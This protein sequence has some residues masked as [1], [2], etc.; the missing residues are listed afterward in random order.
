[1]SAEQQ[2]GYSI[3]AASRLSG[4]S[5]EKIRIWERRYG[6]VSP[7]RDAANHRLYSRED[8][9]RLRLIQHLADQGHAVSTVA[10]LELTALRARAADTSADAE[11][12]ARPGHA[13][14]VTGDSALVESLRALGVR[15]VSTCTT[16]AGA[17]DWLA[18]GEADLL[19]IDQPT[20]LGQ[21]VAGI[22]RLHRL[23]PRTPML[24]TYRFAARTVL[25]QLER[26][27][28]RVSKAPLEVQ[29]LLNPTA[30]RL[31]PGAAEAPA[32]EAA[33]ARRYAPDALHRLASLA[34]TVQCECP[35]H[36]ADLV[37]DLQAFEDYSLGCES[38]SPDDAALHREI[39][40]VI[41]HARALVEDALGIVAA[42]EGI[43]L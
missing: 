27:G 3:S 35:R 14:A 2:G 6:A 20:L 26:L 24:V 28:I 19:L 17:G 32:P 11:Q 40:R 31:T 38:A 30:P 16:L 12:P 23:A 9:E 8:V 36:L 33:P 15:T 13:L 4:V 7:G 25:S 10:T 43:T 39:H 18:D 5:P 42:E 21:D 22:V 29:D 37:N 1:M 41:A 34:D